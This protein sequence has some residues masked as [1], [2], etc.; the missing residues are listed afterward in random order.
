[1]PADNRIAGFEPFFHIWK[2]IELAFFEHD[3]RHRRRSV[4][5]QDE[6]DRHAFD[7]T[8]TR[9]AGSERPLGKPISKGSNVESAAELLRDL[10]RHRAGELRRG[11]LMN[12]GA[13]ALL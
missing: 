4:A 11:E 12:V 2:M 9:A 5:P 13:V 8:Q 1:M 3:H 6:R 7:M 10:L